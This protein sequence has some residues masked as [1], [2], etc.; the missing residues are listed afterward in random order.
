MQMQEAGP[1]YENVEFDWE[2]SFDWEFV[3]ETSESGEGQSIYSRDIN[4][5]LDLIL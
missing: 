2:N 1:S 5:L 3:V 4:N